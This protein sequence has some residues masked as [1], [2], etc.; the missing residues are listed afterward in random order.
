MNFILF[1]KFGVKMFMK[2][3]F[4]SPRLSES[5]LVKSTYSKIRKQNV[6]YIL[7]VFIVCPE[8]VARK[9]SAKRCSY[10]V[11]KVQRKI[12]VS[13]SVAGTAVCQLLRELQKLSSR[14]YYKE[15]LSL[16]ISSFSMIIW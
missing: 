8:A 5:Y 2:T 12:L 14:C 15:F 11:C 4:L 10:K 9:F 3:S 16:S 13:E 1:Y 7:L 6:H